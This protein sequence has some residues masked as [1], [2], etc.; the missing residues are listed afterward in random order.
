MSS[1]LEFLGL[2]TAPWRCQSL[3]S[4]L[5]AFLSRLQVEALRLHGAVTGLGAKIQVE[6][7]AQDLSLIAG[8]GTRIVEA[9][10]AEGPL[11]ERRLGEVLSRYAA[12]LT[13]ALPK[14]APRGAVA[15]GLEVFRKSLEDWSLGRLEKLVFML[16]EANRGARLRYESKKL[17]RIEARVLEA[18]EG[19]RSPIE[20]EDALALCWIGL[21]HG[22]SGLAELSWLALP[23]SLPS[24][25]RCRVAVRLALARLE[26]GHR[27]GAERLFAKARALNPRETTLRLAALEVF[28]EAAEPSAEALA[29]LEAQR[30]WPQLRPRLDLIKAQSQLAEDRAKAAF[31]TLA[32]WRAVLSERSAQGGR[33]PWP[34]AEGWLLERSL[35]LLA[36][37]A[38]RAE[39]A[40]SLL[41]LVEVVPELREISADFA[42]AELLALLV[43]NR[44]PEAIAR[45][46]A[47]LREKDDPLDRLLLARALMAEGEAGQ[48]AAEARKARAQVQKLPAES[49]SGAER[50]QFE[51]SLAEA[52]LEA[53]E[54]EASREA[55]QAALQLGPVA[56]ASW[57]VLLARKAE[58][59]GELAKAE[60]LFQS[61]IGLWPDSHFAR[62]EYG[63]LFDC[64]AALRRG[65][66]AA[67][68]PPR[69][70]PALP[71]GPGEPAGGLEPGAG[72]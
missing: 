26:R 46:E 22:D 67:R 12:A 9:F 18:L 32:P 20:P 24:D 25:L 69:E 28:D 52:L 27:E 14:L 51:I 42:R 64:L 43:K 5:G 65:H 29:A 7:R 58:E 47:V 55:F 68:D 44:R 50:Q 36:Q 39:E 56:S 38:L 8:D 54:A 23:D 40:E 62:S 16:E 41:S 57:T 71:S 31:A 60:E 21:A 3:D 11:A 19:E 4:A 72:E 61:A 48:A 15:D 70:P 66:P 63:A 30:D 10:G 13:R 2:E 33:K 59:D 34:Q 53:G 49:L 1:E 6:L 35:I 45:L 17:G 37:A